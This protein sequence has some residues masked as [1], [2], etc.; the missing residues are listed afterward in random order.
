[1]YTHQNFKTKK[2]LKE[3][4]TARLAYKADATMP[5]ARA[6]TVFQPNNMF[7]IEPP[8]NGTVTLEGPHYP[9]PHKWYATATLENGEVVKVS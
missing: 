2:T 9:Q 1:M 3:A 8:L 5:F 6:V 7:N 4:V